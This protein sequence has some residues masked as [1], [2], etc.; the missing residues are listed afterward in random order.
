MVRLVRLTTTDPEG[1]FNND[2]QEDIVVTPQSKIALKSM[3]IEVQLSQIDIASSNDTINFQLADAQGTLSAQLDHI[4]YDTT[5]APGL[6]R[7]MS[8]KMNGKIKT[9][10][11]NVGA[12]IGVEVR[13]VIN[14]D[15]KFECQMKQ[16]K[17]DENTSSIVLDKG[18]VAV[19][20]LASGV[21]KCSDTTTNPPANECFFYDPVPMCRGGG[22]SR[23]RIQNTNSNTDD[24]FIFG[25]SS[26]NPDTIT[27]NSF[28]LSNI[29]YGI[30]LGN[31]T[32][33]YD[34]IL[35]GAISPSAVTPNF[36]GIGNTGNDEL[37]IC[38]DEGKVRVLV[39]NST[40]PDP[41]EVL[42]QPYIYPN[43]LYPVVIFLSKQNTGASARFPAVERFRYTHSPYHT[44]P[45]TTITGNSEELLGSPPQQSFPSNSNH[46]LEFEG[47]SLA[48]FLGFNNTRTP[49]TPGTFVRTNNFRVISDLIFR[50]NNLSDAFLV[51]LNTIQLSSY[52]GLTSQRRSFLT[53]IPETDR[54]GYVIYD[55]SYPI[56]IDIQNSQ[57]ISIR[58]LQARILNNDGSSIAMRGL[59]SLVLLIEDK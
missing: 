55:A 6:F 36:I 47:E 13:N 7:D 52:D 10:G 23:F 21:Y 45:E 28:P 9:T 59:G 11:V 49:V 18:S 38:I 32:S 48:Q 26:V 22:V 35:N 54:N 27:G 16:A 30:Q 33:N 5:S 14:S 51:E 20:R 42:N 34:S 57:P 58:N 40:L 25:L 43:D 39:Y 3:S 2:F 53:V 1:I 44:Q 4:S 19:T 24:N 37:V 29:E 41:T 50:P 46:F 56:F 15:R 8:I 17:L 12:S 31:T